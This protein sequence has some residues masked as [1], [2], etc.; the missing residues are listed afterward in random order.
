MTSAELLDIWRRRAR[1]A[2]IGH[3]RSA[4]K[5]E[6]RH[7]RLGVIA[8]ALNAVVGTTVFASLSE[9]VD[10][11]WIKLAVGFVSV[12]TAVLAGVQTFER[13][14]ERAEVHRQAATQFSALQREAELYQTTGD[15]SEVSVEKFLQDFN[16]RYVQL[17]K[18]APTADEALH[19]EAKSIVKQEAR[20]AV[21]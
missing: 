11:T 19:L 8:V 21:A 17:V 20:E 18:E 1:V 16:T 14:G 15:N 10:T 9:D 5:L 13:A 3:Y 2:Q 7:R 6:N 4:V 12:V